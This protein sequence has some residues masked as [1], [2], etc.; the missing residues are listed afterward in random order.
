MGKVPEAI[1]QSHVDDLT[2]MTGGLTD[3]KLNVK[4]PYTF[5]ANLHTRSYLPR[6]NCTHS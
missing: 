5:G 6:R 1:D 2:L 3:Q 4:K